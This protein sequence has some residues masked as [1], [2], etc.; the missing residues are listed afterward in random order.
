MSTVQKRKLRLREATWPTQYYLRNAA[1]TQD[2]CIQ[3]LPFL[4]HSTV[5]V[6]DSLLIIFHMRGFPTKPQSTTSCLVPGPS[7]LLLTKLG[8][9][10]C[11]SA[12]PEIT[13]SILAHSLGV[14]LRHTGEPGNTSVTPRLVTKPVL[15]AWTWTCFPGCDNWASVLRSQRQALVSGPGVDPMLTACPKP[16]VLTQKVLSQPF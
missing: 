9:L 10:G 14:L 15:L 12:T 11:I 2:F 7:S 8:S 5:M 1:W 4:Y 16:Q 6:H 3:I 13:G